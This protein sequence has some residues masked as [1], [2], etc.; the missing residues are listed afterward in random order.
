MPSTPVHDGFPIQTLAMEYVMLVDGA[1]DQNPLGMPDQVFNDSEQLLTRI[2][3]RLG[4]ENGRE[5]IN[6]ARKAYEIMNG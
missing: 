6:K 5:V 2:Y 4:M 3:R 1:P